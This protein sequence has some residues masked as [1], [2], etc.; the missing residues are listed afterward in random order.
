MKEYCD[1]HTDRPREVRVLSLGEDSNFIVC[2]QGHIKEIAFR[3]ERNAEY[4]D[5]FDLPTWE[6]L[7]KYQAD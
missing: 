7:K 4:P 1:C 2:K 6:S 3:K 5:M